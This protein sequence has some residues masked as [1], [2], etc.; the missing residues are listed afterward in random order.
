MRALS[1][2]SPLLL[3]LMA[4]TTLGCPP[5]LGDDDDATGDDDDATGDDDDG[6]MD[7]DDATGDDD[8]DVC[9]QIGEGWLWI[10]AS[11]GST[12]PTIFEG[13]LAWDGTTL[14]VTPDIG[15][16]FSLSISAE[17][18]ELDNLF[19]G[20]WGYGRVMVEATSWGAWTP[21]GVVA[22]ISDDS[23]TQ[24]ALGTD[25]TGADG[26][27][28]VGLGVWVT[29]ALEV[30]TEPL[31]DVDG[32]GMGAAL[33][34]DWA[35]PG[36]EGVRTYPGESAWYDGWS[37]NQYRSYAIFESNCEDFDNVSVSWTLRWDGAID[38]LR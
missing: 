9:S 2:D 8:D 16:T 10:D 26:L 29:P 30:C 32:C 14:S 35:L 27:S 37:L 33:P 11:A 36:L 24:V 23:G 18:V 22:V 19:S 17:G 6:T 12:G 21:K 38:G 25:G 28:A 31:V 34:L 3:L 20:I 1:S 15:P 5:S 13:Q 4:L 7:D